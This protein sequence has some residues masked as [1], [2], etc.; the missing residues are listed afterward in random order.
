MMNWNIKSKRFIV[1]A[2]ING[3]WIATLAINHELFRFLT[4][5]VI[6]F[7]GGYV[8]GETWRPSGLDGIK[9]E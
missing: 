5:W 9:S 7:N 4:P 6:G 3:V 8:I 2:V 1:V